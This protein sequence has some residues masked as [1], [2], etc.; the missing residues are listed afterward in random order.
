M[1]RYIVAGGTCWCV[2]YMVPIFPPILAGTARMLSSM[3][4]EGSL[5][6]RT[7]EAAR[8]LLTGERR[9]ARGY[10]AFAGPA[11]VASI[12]YMD[13]GNFAPVLGYR[14]GRGLLDSRDPLS[15]TLPL[16]HELWAKTDVVLAVGTRMLMQQH[17]G[18]AG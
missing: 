1:M 7:V 11:V 10:L 9:G 13:P 2:R 4:H 17:R 3:L 16:A 12:A 15:V 8:A 5:S 14:R 6:D 18:I